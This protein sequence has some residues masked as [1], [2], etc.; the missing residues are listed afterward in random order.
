MSFPVAAVHFDPAIV[1]D[2]GERRRFH[3]AAEPSVLARGPVASVMPG[4]KAGF[5]MLFENNLVIRLASEAI[6]PPTQSQ[7]AT[8]SVQE[9]RSMRRENS[10]NAVQ[11]SFE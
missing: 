9:R 8:I 4:G 6:E 10:S 1:I 7:M 5:Q 2:C 11:G 3:G